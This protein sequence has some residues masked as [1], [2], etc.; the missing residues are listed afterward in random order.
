MVSNGTQ[1]SHELSYL[2]GFKQLKY[3]IGI[4]QLF[5]LKVIEV[6]RRL[7]KVMY[8]AYRTQ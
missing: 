2:L 5:I 3:N 6:K 1:C 7:W 8:I 4:Q